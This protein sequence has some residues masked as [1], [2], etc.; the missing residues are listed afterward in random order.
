MKLEEL[1]KRLK[2]FLMILIIFILGFL[3]GYWGKNREYEEKLYRNAIEITDLKE[4]IDRLEQMK[5]LK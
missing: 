3:V 2:V 5:K 1:E 4:S